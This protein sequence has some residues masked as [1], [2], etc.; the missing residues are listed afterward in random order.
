MHD[1]LFR[2][3]NG[4]E[5]LLQLYQSCDTAALKIIT[6]VT[7]DI[8]MKSANTSTKQS[9]IVSVKGDGA[10]TAAPGVTDL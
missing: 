1:D 10:F 9:L 5:L 2:N 6:F 8:F 7:N 4:G 3:D